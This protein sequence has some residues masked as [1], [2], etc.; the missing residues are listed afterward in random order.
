MCE[1]VWLSFQLDCQLPKLHLSEQSLVKIFYK[2]P[3]YFVISRPARQPCPSGWYEQTPPCSEPY[4]P[5]SG[6]QHVL[7]IPAKNV[8]N[9]T[10][11]CF[12]MNFG[13][14]S[15]KIRQNLRESQ[16]I[17]V[18]RSSDFLQIW[19]QS[20]QLWKRAHTACSINIVPQCSQIFIMDYGLRNGFGTFC[21]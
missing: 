2:S 15:K 19:S 20:R 21:S 5:T 16:K 11:R 9:H 12:P 8:K 17:C 10:C 4:S 3:N 18:P 7:T 1:T 14:V 13:K 6:S